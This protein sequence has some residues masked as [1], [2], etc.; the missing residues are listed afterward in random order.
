MITD[1]DLLSLMAWLSPSFPVG[2][3]SYSH[4]LETAVE[5][6]IVAD[7]DGLIDW[8][9]AILRHGPARNDAIVFRAIHR[10]VLTGDEAG[11]LEVAE[12]AAAMRGTRELALEA[13]AQGAAFL[14][15]L[16]AAFADPTRARWTGMLEGAAIAPSHAVAVA[17]AL[18]CS[19]VAWRPAL[20]AYAQAFT[21]N[22]VSA[23]LRLVPLGQSDGQRALAALSPA[24]IALLDE[25]EGADLADLGSAT[26]R[27][28]L[29]S[30]R[31]ETQYTRLFRS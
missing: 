11:L 5:D 22:L 25:I 20:L 24:L 17:L 18:A 1:R 23:G 9:G 29:S 3:F 13:N 6:G 8:L 26:M 16:D 10:A 4:G 15:T 27:V 14:A 2:G 19:G 30:M 31:H 28:D 12:R 21:A 7:R